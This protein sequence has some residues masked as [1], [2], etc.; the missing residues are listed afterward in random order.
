MQVKYLSRIINYINL[1][2]INTAKSL[3]AKK[4]AT[5][6]SK[7]DSTPKAII[8]KYIPPIDPYTDRPTL[9]AVL[10]QLLPQK[11]FNLSD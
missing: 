3:H 11:S 8:S 6:S 9:S 5:L 4:Q 2:K 1:N 7:E 10:F